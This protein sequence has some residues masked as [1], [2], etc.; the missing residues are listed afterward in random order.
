MR[1]VAK[2]IALY[3][4]SVMVAVLSVAAGNPQA[5]PKPTNVTASNTTEEHVLVSWADDAAPVH[6]VGWTQDA[7]FRAAYAAGDW[8]ETFHFAATRRNTDYAI[9]YLPGEQLY[10]LIVEAGAE[11]FGN[12]S[13]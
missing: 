2:L 10:W 11:R 6:R 7:E 9:K 4:T 13:Q 5:Y 3:S 8:L 1:N 12:I